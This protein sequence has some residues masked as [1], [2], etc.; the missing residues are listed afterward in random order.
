MD[1]YGWNEA[2]PHTDAYINGKIVELIAG[3]SPKR[4]CD[5]GCGNGVLLAQINQKVSAS[6][7]GVEQDAIGAGLA[8]ARCPSAEIHNLSIEDGSGQALPPGSF[9]VVVSTEVIEH[10]FRPE[11]LITFSRDI[12][13]N[14]GH[15]ILS[16]PYHGYLKNLAIA[17]AGGWDKHFTVDWNGGH[18]KFFSRRTLSTLLESNGF[19]VVGFY[20]VGRMPYLWKSMVM[21]ARK[22]LPLV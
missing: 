13:R 10:L 20:G 2:A 9:D 22:S 1:S 7:S 11:S 5:V 3:L 15:L 16:T 6:L 8:T 17:L 14:G 18:I 21:V 19:E 4:V 12:L